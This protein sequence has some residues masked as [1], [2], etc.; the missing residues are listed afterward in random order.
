MANHFY[1]EHS[2]YCDYYDYYVYCVYCVWYQLAP[3][4]IS[5]TT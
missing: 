2:D 1:F 4:E 5:C 3:S